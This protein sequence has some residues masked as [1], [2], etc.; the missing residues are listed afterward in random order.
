MQPTGYAI[1]GQATAAQPLRSANAMTSTLLPV[2]GVSVVAARASCKWAPSLANC[3]AS[4][5]ARSPSARGHAIALSRRSLFRLGRSPPM[6]RCR[7][8]S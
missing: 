4:A 6:R 1:A 8:S 5:R 3:G 7:R 2:Q